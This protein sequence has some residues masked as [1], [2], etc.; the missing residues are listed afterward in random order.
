MVVWFSLTPRSTLPRLRRHQ[1]IGNRQRQRTPSSISSPPHILS[2]SRN[3]CW[4]STSR[5]STTKRSLLRELGVR[6]CG[7]TGKR[8]CKKQD[9]ALINIQKHGRKRRRTHAQEDSPDSNPHPDATRNR[10]TE[11]ECA[12][13]RIC[14]N[15]RGRE[16]AQLLSPRLHA[17]RT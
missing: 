4:P 13:A 9:K 6:E 15:T 7:W 17:Q 1:S 12:T 16:S 5:N 8:N 14:E 10:T 11:A 3:K 2:A